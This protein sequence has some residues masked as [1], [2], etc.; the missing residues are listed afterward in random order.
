MKKILLVSNRTNSLWFFRKEIIISLIK[1]NYE[2]IMVANK[3]E[4]YKKF[5]KYNVRFYEIKKN[6]NSFNPFNIL[7]LLFK[8]I[9]ISLKHKPDIIQS[10]TIVPN[11]VCPLIKIFHKCKVFC[12]ITGMGYVLSSGNKFLLFFSSF[13]YKF[14]LLLCDHL[15][16]TNK[17]NLKFFINNR[18]YKKS[19]SHSLIPASGVNKNKYKKIKLYKKNN[20]TLFLFVGRLIKSKGIKDL[21]Y[22]FNKLQ[23]RNKKLL[24]IGKEDRF[25][26]EAVNINNLIK[27]N[28]KIHHIKESNYLEKYYNKA[29]IFL[30]PSYS[31]GMP[32]VVMEAFS[33]GLPCFTYKVPGCDDIV[34]NN[35]TGFKVKLHLKDQM[36]RIIEK[37]VLNKKK[38]Q[39][40]SKNCIKFSKKFDRDLVVEKIVKLYEKS[41]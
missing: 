35:H 16:F 31:E 17:S 9:I 23:I 21:I 24:I 22:I 39:Q 7:N 41:L 2:V 11:L 34:I 36:V 28:K 6:I 25:S 40:I 4:Y 26:P 1:N 20:E 30:F 8:L 5:K 37:E 3:D 15:I 18:L 32:T 14:S 12:M 38:M 13:F 10:Y 33:C 27:S 19:N 29:D